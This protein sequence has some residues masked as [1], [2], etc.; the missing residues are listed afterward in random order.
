MKRF[1]TNK[2]TLFFLGV[3]FLFLLWIVISLILDKNG[4][5]FPSPILTFQ[6][7]L[8]LLKE[9]YTYKCVAY[10]LMR[11]GVGFSVSFILAFIFG[12]LAGNHLYLYQFLKPLM[13]VLRSIPTVALVFVFIVLITP[14]NAPIL[15]VAIICFPILFEG[16]AG[17]VN[18]IDKQ[19]IDA[20]KVDG[21]GY[22]RTIANVKLPL[23]LPY[24]IVSMISSFALSFK[25][26]IMAEAMTG[27]TKD[28]LGSVIAFAKGDAEDPT[29]MV[30]IFAYALF[31]I[32]LMLIVSL[33][34]E[35]VAQYLKRKQLVIINNN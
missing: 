10:T 3:V 4:S 28:G 26:E 9:P 6:K 24:I 7:F 35:I 15:L 2:F 12:I 27:T 30:T 18:N 11:M 32:I 19:Y 33:I 16:F 34:E 8:E 5:I 17:G 31:A 20:A 25:I 14:R 22:F 1:I 21:A 23:A 13:V 29:P